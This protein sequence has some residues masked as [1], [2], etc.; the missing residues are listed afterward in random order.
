MDAGSGPVAVE[1][2]ETEDRADRVGGSGRQLFEPGEC[3]KLV[4]K[5]RDAKLPTPDAELVDIKGKRYYRV[6]VGPVVE[7]AEAE[8]MAARVSEIAGTRTQVHSTRDACS[9]SGRHP[10][11]DRIESPGGAV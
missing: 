7:R 2:G 9:V 1:A 6:K 5:L 8:G 10:A 11:S 3:R 4:A